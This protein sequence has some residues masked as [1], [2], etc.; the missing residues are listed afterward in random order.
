MNGGYED[1]GESLLI[2]LLIVGDII[3]GIIGA[4]IGGWLLPQLGVHLGAGTI[5][6]IINACASVAGPRARGTASS[7]EAV[8]MGL[9]VME[10]VINALKH[11]FLDRADGQIIVAYD[12]AE[13]E[14]T[15]TIS[16]DGVSKPE[17]SPELTF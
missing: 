8:S 10:L 3:I 16:D 14:W 5:A 2:I 7:S 13:T 6:A 1:S 9:I 15:M 4:F 12:I 11:A 17:G